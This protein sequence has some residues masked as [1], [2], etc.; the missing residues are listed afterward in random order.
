M[1]HYQ[2]KDPVRRFANPGDDDLARQ[3]FSEML[4]SMSRS[5]VH[6]SCAN[7]SG[8]LHVVRVVPHRE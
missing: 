3:Q 2:S 6:A 7:S 1:I 5:D 4:I 8:E